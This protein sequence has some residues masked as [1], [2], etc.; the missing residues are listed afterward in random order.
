MVHITSTVAPRDF[1]YGVATPRKRIT[2]RDLLNRFMEAMIAARRRQ[3]DRE[4]GRFLRDN[5]GKLTDDVERAIE[6]RFFT[7]L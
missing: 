1:A 2:A 5:G 7:T 3:V 4:I 6:R